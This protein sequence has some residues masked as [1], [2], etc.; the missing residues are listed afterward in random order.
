MRSAP[1]ASTLRTS[2]PRVAKLAAKTDGASLI[3]PDVI[4]FSWWPGPVGL[5]AEHALCE[6]LR[7]GHAF[8]KDLIALAIRELPADHVRQTLMLQRHGSRRRLDSFGRYRQ[9]TLIFYGDVE[10]AGFAL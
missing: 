10:R 6:Y 8:G 2:S 5:L 3:F 4:G 7:H 9:A 1:A